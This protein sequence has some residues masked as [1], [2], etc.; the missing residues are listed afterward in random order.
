MVE[1]QQ[2]CSYT[3]MESAPSA[4]RSPRS[5][6]SPG[7]EETP[8]RAPVPH[9]HGWGT[10]RAGASLT[11]M[12]RAD[13]RR[14][15]IETQPRAAVP[16]RSRDRTQTGL[17]HTTRSHDAVRDRKSKVSRRGAETRKSIFSFSPRRRGGLAAFC[18]SAAGRV[19]AGAT[20]HHSRSYGGPAL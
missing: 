17:A 11:E 20:R 5:P 16:Q 14:H 19:P 4:A 10:D 3:S 2:G 13:G 18:R 6:E 7:S 15:I 8:A 1:T 9:V 12:D